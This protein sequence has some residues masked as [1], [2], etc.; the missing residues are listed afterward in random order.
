MLLITYLLTEQLKTN[1]KELKIFET[2]QKKLVNPTKKCA[3]KTQK[4]SIRKKTGLGNNQLETV[5]DRSEK[6]RS[7]RDRPKKTRTLQNRTE[8]ANVQLYPK[9]FF[10][11]PGPFILN[12]EKQ[13]GSPK[14]NLYKVFFL[15]S[16]TSVAFCISVLR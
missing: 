12:D 1:T 10:V 5:R 2:E 15:G 11:S 6:T 16:K 9:L 3:R 4:R 7:F 14:A 13:R 8:T